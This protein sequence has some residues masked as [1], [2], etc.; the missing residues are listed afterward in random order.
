MTNEDIGRWQAAATASFFDTKKANAVRRAIMTDV[1]NPSEQALIS[2]VAGQPMKKP[3]EL[4][5]LLDRLDQ[6]THETL[7]QTRAGLPPGARLIK[8]PKGEAQVLQ[9]GYPV[10]QGWEEIK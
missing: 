3:Q 10:P 9:R 1:L 8:G 7:K 2:Q 4:R 6:V 5:S